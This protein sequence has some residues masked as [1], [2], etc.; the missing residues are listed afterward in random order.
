MWWSRRGLVSSLVMINKD[1]KRKIPDD[2]WV[3]CVHVGLFKLA[4]VEL[5]VVVWSRGA[6]VVVVVT[7]CGDGDGDGGGR[8]VWCVVVVVMMLVVVTACGGVW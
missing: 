5:W 6:V 8:G 3:V 7:A 4:V 2:V 1:Y